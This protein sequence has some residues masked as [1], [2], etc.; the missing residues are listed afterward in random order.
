MTVMQII[1]QAARMSGLG[2][3]SSFSSCH[4][5]SGAADNGVGNGLGDLGAYGALSRRRARARRR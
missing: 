2:Q 1:E 4:C 3:D 5:A